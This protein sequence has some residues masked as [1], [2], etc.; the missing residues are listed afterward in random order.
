MVTSFLFRANPAGTVAAGPTFWPIEESSEV[1]GFYRDFLPAAPRE[2]NG[3]FAYHYVPPG[4]PFPEEIHGRHICGVVW[5]YLGSEDELA[6]LLAPILD[7]GNPILHGVASV[8][9]AAFNGAFDALYSAGDQWYWKADFVREITDEA[10]Q[11]HTEWGEK[12]PTPKSTMHLY[13]IDGVAHD[14]GPSETAWAYRDARWGSVMAGV[15]PDPAN[16]DVVRDWST[17]YWEALHP[18][19]AGGAYV[20]MMMDDEGQERV[21]ASYGDN[22]ERLARIKANYDPENAFRVNQNIQPQH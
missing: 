21:R 3:F 11:L 2:L 1:L 9:F 12:L 8:P 6:K 7:V 10:V 18:H 16:Q 4:P 13:P 20:S 14:V 19:S 17:G 5:N 22:Y 15:D